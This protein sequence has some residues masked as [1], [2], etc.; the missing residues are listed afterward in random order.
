MYKKRIKDWAIDKNLKSERPHASPRTRQQRDVPSESRPSSARSAAIGA[1]MLSIT[2]NSSPDP[3]QGFQYGTRPSAEGST[4]GEYYTPGAMLP[5]QQGQY[6][7]DAGQSYGD[8]SYYSSISQGGQSGEQARNSVLLSS[9]RDRFL[10]ASDAIAR[11]D[12]TVLFEI[13]NPAYEAISSVAETETAQLLTVVVD[14]FQVLSRRPNHQDML[15]Q[16]LH[17][18]FALVPD[19]VRQNQFFSS[20]SQVLALLGQ[21]GSAF[22]SSMSLDTAGGTNSRL[23]VP[24]QKYTYYEQPSGAGSASGSRP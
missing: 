4:Q 6:R 16:L 15:R 3:V 9:I 23:A 18:V 20:N 17:Y 7:A 24:T 13:L 14:L 8:Y 22:P 10:E 5:L 2:A 1:Q 19:A 11:H 12:T 21:S